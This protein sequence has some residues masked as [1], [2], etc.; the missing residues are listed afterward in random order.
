MKAFINVTHNQRS[1]RIIKSEY[2]HCMVYGTYYSTMKLSLINLHLET[3]DKQTI[4]AVMIKKGALPQNTCN[5][6]TTIFHNRTNM[7]LDF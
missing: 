6:K 7:M 5:N 3:Q 2:Y 1:G 4:I